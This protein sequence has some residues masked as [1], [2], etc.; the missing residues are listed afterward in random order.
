[1]KKCLTVAQLEMKNHNGVT[2][3]KRHVCHESIFQFLFCLDNLL[4]K[5][6]T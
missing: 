5:Y 4:F 6:L 2:V 3:K 1:M